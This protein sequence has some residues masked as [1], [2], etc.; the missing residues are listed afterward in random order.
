MKKFITLAGMVW[1]F[2]SCEHYLN[3]KSDMSLAIPSSVKDL[4]AIMDYELNSVI[5]YPMAGDVGSDYYYVNDAR[6]NA[7]PARIQDG[8][9][10]IGTESYDADW[11]DGYK[12][13]FNANLVI[14]EV[15]DVTLNGL[16]E[17]DRDRVK[18]TAY[19]LRG[20]SLLTLAII[21]AP[22]FD[23]KSANS[24]L[25][26]PLRTTAD[27]NVDFQRAT[28]RETF[29]RITD[30]L[31]TSVVLLPHVSEKPT[32]PS[33]GAA[34]AALSR[35]YL[36]MGNHHLA[37]L[38]ADSCLQINNSLID[39]SE[40]DTTAVNPFDLFNEE[41]ILHNT[42]ISN[43]NLFSDG[44]VRVDSVLYASY[45][46]SDFRKRI[47]YKKMDDGGYAFKGNYS[48]VNNSLL[49]SGISVSEMFLLKV[50][51]A[52]RLGLLDQARSYLET[53]LN[54][55]YATDQ[56][57]SINLSQQDLISFVLEERKKELAFRAGIRWGDVKRLNEQYD[58][59]IS[60]RRKVGGQFYDLPAG[61]NRFVYLIP[62]DVI[63]LGDL[64]QN[65]R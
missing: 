53:F 2:V 12:K 40:I 20:W 30:D 18:G 51:S 36:Y 5:S 22:S 28:L 31:K 63:Q 33:R 7:L 4:Q 27:I 65:D 9:L 38:Y 50:E 14:E 43:N 45:S 26:L 1:C 35:A 32:R 42:M 55:R 59:N 44:N 19:F 49:F 17:V 54:H 52:S 62:R 46:D 25:G 21:Y 41:V 56:M 48:G 15:D 24:R 60:L 13:I 47:F 64:I 10:F 6:L 37:N 39:Y 57:P 58:A 23:E 8:Y 34:Y 61:D 29:Q 3:K 16:N 11:N